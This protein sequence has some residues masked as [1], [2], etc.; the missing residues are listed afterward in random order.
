M[1]RHLSLVSNSYYEIKLDNN[2]NFPTIMTCIE[3]HVP[4]T[5]L[6]DVYVPLLL[7][8]WPFCDYMMTEAKKR[9]RGRRSYVLFRSC[10]ARINVCLRTY[11]PEC[12]SL[13]MSIAVHVA[14]IEENNSKDE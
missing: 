13:C 10:L 1:N 4:N 12:F 9:L 5:G 11:L 6:A 14:G 3:N 8:Y 2:P 7:I